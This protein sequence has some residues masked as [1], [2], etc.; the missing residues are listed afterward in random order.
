MC[1]VTSFA[2]RDPDPHGG[3]GD[4]SLGEALAA[5]AEPGGPSWCSNPYLELGPSNAATNCM[6]CHQ[7]GGTGLAPED[8]LADPARFPADGRTELRNNFPMDYSWTVDRGDRLADLIDAEVDYYD[9][10]DP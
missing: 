4:S 5:V 1:V 9:G 3:F 6:G 10:F 7:H 8:I 2:E